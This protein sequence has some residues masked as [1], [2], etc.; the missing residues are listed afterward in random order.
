LLIADLILILTY[1][2]LFHG[3]ILYY[4]SIYI[5]TQNLDTQNPFLLTRTVPSY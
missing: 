1:V 5:D 3:L 4:L 2:F